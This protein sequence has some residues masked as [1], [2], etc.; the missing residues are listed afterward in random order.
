MAVFEALLCKMRPRCWIIYEAGHGSSQWGIERW[1]S[2]WGGQTACV[3]MLLYIF[4]A[5][6]PIRMVGGGVLVTT[7]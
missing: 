6:A 2:V 1:L 4:V 3:A 5:M 7:G